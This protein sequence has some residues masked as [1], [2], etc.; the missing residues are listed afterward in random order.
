MNE[1]SMI[2]ILISGIDEIF[3]NSFFCLKML[4]CSMNKI[5]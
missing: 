2:V 4:E 1:N 3:V 5:S